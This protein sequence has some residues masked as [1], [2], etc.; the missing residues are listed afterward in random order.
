MPE[1]ASDYR[2]FILQNTRLT[3]P[4]L[5]PEIK[6]H[7]ADASMPLWQKTV[8]DLEGIGIEPPYWAFAWAGGQALARYLCDNPPI[9]TQKRVYD[10]GAGSGLTAIAAANSGAFSV[11]AVDIDPLARAAI[12]LNSA[13][14]GASLRISAAD[15]TSGTTVP[16]CDILL[17]GDL[18]YEFKLASNVLSLAKR[19]RDA[20]ML[21][22]TG[23]PQRNYFP[24]EHF[25][26]L[27]EYM[28][29]VSRDLEDTDFKKTAVWGMKT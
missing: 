23:D 28:V 11:T 20:G 10:L 27:S 25:E 22:L 29:P 19:C 8:D 6:L 9:V 16:P 21:V 3:R 18:F 2:T 5:V 15:L 4:T 13:H 14:N 7:L 24:V 1:T 17:I 26:L 12:A